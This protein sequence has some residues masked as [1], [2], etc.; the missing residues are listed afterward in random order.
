MTNKLYVAGVGPGTNEFVLPIVRNLV[1]QSEVIIGG[2]RNLELF[3]VE[4]K[5]TIVIKN[6][7]DEICSYIAGHLQQKKIIVLASGDP[8]IYGIAAYLQKKLPGIE[9]EIIPGVSSLQY[10]CAKLKISWEDI[11]ITS[12]HGRKINNLASV[13][14]KN[15]KTAVFTGDGFQAQDVCRLLLKEG[16]DE[17]TVAVGEN[18]SYAKERI[19]SGKPYELAKMEFDALSLMII[20]NENFGQEIRKWE[21]RTPG[22]PDE[23]FIRGKVPLTKEEIR[24]VALSKLRLKEDSIVCDI[25]AGTG[26]IAIESALLC[27]QGLVYAVE[28]NRE[29]IDLIQKN[30]RNFGVQNLKIIA[31]EAPLA[32]QGLEDVDRVFIGGSGGAMAEIIAWAANLKKDVKVAVNAITIETL[33]A[34]LDSLQKKNFKK[35][36]LAQLFV[37]KGKKVADKNLME[38]LN[39]VYIISAEKAEAGRL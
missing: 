16:L 15:Q 34:A 9:M 33:A 17:V 30:M 37:A 4:D 31:G 23:R 2:Q 6:N 35:I 25:G 22:I 28:K 27:P 5:E 21:Y 29:A 3:A 24:T 39:P 32:L 18:L 38:A 11:Y 26:S 19:S 1:A 20:L 8:G 10:L 14:S 12:L 7:L 13:I 36:E